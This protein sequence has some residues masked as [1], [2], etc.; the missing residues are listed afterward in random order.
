MLFN[1]K[2]LHSPPLA[3]NVLSNFLLRRMKKTTTGEDAPT[4]WISVINW[5]LPYTVADTLRL[6]RDIHSNG[7]F[8][9]FIVSWAVMFSFPNMIFCFIQ[10]KRFKHLQIIAG[11][12]LFLFWLSKLFWNFTVWI[13]IV[14]VGLIVVVL[15]I[16]NMAGFDTLVSL[17][18]IIILC[19]C[20][21]FCIFALV[22]VLAFIPLFN[23]SPWHGYMYSVILGFIIGMIYL[24]IIISHIY[25]MIC[26][27][28]LMIMTTYSFQDRYQCRLC[29]WFPATK[30]K[31]RIF[32]IMKRPCSGS[33]VGF[34]Y[35]Q[36]MPWE[37]ESFMSFLQ[38]D[39]F[40]NATS[41]ILNSKI[42]KE[43]RHIFV[44]SVRR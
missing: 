26:L 24:R 30:M 19:C 28:V 21:G 29:L 44:V 27:N 17:L 16:F 41:W 38:L 43:N 20:Y 12:N 34:Y 13:G 23:Q 8:A 3:V 4:N 6:D 5:P 9:G 33:T 40:K 31:P 39:I 10:E 2:I 1:N 7:F 25:S 36:A 15:I 11:L 14:T 35:F 37:W 18:S 22:G 32:T 42:A